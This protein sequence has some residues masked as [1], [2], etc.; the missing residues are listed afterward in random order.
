M[1]K[2]QPRFREGIY[3][4]P[5]AARWGHGHPEEAGYKYPSPGLC[6]FAQ[7]G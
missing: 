4:C 3:G 7:F 2:F 6:R 5:N 1:E